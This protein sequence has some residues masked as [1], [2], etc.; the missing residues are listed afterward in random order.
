MLDWEFSVS[1]LLTF[2]Q[3]LSPFMETA[4]IKAY[5]QKSR[6]LSYTSH[7]MHLGQMT[8]DCDVRKTIIFSNCFLKHNSLGSG[9]RT[10]NYLNAMGG[11]GDKSVDGRVEMDSSDDFLLPDS[12]LFP[13][14]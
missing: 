6:A 12:V 2:S 1:P 14:L 7:L 9:A 11:L 13:A 3:H 5:C 8:G 4:L 10:W